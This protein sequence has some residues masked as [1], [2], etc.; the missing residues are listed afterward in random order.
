MNRAGLP[1]PLRIVAAAV[2]A[3][4]FVVLDYAM[5][6]SLAGVSGA[7]A[8]FESVVVWAALLVLAAALRPARVVLA[9]V[10]ASLVVVQAFAYRFA[11]APFDLQVAESARHS[12]TAIRPVLARVLPAAA[13]AIIVVSAVELALLE[14]A[15]P[16]LGRLRAGWR[17]RV[18][19]AALV[20]VAIAVAPEPRASCPDVRAI[21]ALSVF[22]S[23]PAPRIEGAVAL[24]PLHSTRGEVPD[25]LFVLTES[26]RAADY[27]PSGPE[28]TAAAAAE[29]TSGRFELDELRSISSYTAV[30]LSALITG[31]SQEG[32][33]EDI[34]NAPNLFDFAHALGAD[35]GYYS[36]QSRETFETKDVRAAVDHFVTLETLAGH[37]VEDDAE[38]V[39]K[40]LD[41]MV[42]DRFL[43]ELPSRP[44]PS[45]TVLHLYGTHAPYY[46]E[47]ER[48]KFVPFEREVGWS[49]MP[50]LRNAYRNAIAE[51]DRQIARAVSAFTSRAGQRPWI[52]VFTSDH[53]ESFG[54]HG[55]I[56]HGQ[57]LY[58]EQV[59]VPGW[60]AAKEGTLDPAQ[61]R[62]LEDHRQRF[63]THLDVLPTVLDALGLLDNFAVR[64]H[65]ERMTG[66][67][68]LRPYA[69]RAPIPVTNCTR[70]FPC[71]LNTW[72]LFADDHK[73]VAQVWDA[74][75]RCVRV[76]G[77]EHLV[78]PDDPACVTLG[79]AAR[80][81]F[82]ELPNGAPNR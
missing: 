69:T 8:F 59:H 13:G 42:V 35:V 50:K 62:S 26:V 46:F 29:V 6:G 78:P 51:Q 21:H 63:V 19:L 17:A 20:V 38:W 74:E 66:H 39:E 49:G 57:N 37:D 28:A 52:V 14:L 9:V 71:P 36:A 53:G 54:E 55:A 31:R 81:Q 23:K 76:G 10:A 25:V 61:R 82:Q 32:S 3:G 77:G 70:M 75:W 12:Y 24:A 45:A 65:V 60:I 56:H 11:H 1:R 34:L 18:A 64:A 7:R 2:F 44:H 16:E 40:P 73:L 58:D 80:R 30:S 47:D 79:Q 5:G 43:A 4:Q 67:S 72:G 22:R 33:R 41:R 48:A 68:L 15:R 27:V